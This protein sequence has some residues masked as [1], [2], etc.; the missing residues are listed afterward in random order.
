MVLL[1]MPLGSCDANADA[2][3]VTSPESYVALHFDQHDI[4]SAVVPLTM[5]CALYHQESHAV[6]HFYDLGG[7]KICFHL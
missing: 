7:L 1:T 5:L 2:I 6:L 4:R 3:V